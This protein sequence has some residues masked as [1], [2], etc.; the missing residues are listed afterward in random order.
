MPE[1]GHT[2][3]EADINIA[4]LW[5][6]VN[7]SENNPGSYP[8]NVEL[9]LSDDTRGCLTRNI[10]MLC[11]IQ[12]GFVVLENSGNSVEVGSSRSK[13]YTMRHNIYSAAQ[14]IN[15]YRGFT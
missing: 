8:K 14:I 12:C 10:F 5:N 3:T 2:L 11:I 1:E 15:V 13:S 4:H 7:S 9:S 6:E